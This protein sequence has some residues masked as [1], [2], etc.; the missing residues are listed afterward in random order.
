MLK[1][2]FWNVLIGIDQL[3]N[4]MLF[5]DPDQTISGRLGKYLG[6][7]KSTWQYKIANVVC[8]FLRKIDKNHCKNAIEKDEGKDAII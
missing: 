2:Y 8:W 7:D 4:A 6:Y 1:K 3:A 5:G